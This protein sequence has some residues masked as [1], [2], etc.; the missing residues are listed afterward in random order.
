MAMLNGC[1]IICEGPMAEEKS[2]LQQMLDRRGAIYDEYLK[3]QKGLEQSIL[4]CVLRSADIAPKVVLGVSDRMFT[5]NEGKE[6]F[7]AIAALVHEGQPVDPVTVG[8]KLNKRGK[9]LDVG[10]APTLVKLFHNTVTAANIDRYIRDMRRNYQLRRIEQI[11]TDMAYDALENRS[12][13]DILASAGSKL[14]SLVNLSQ[15]TEGKEM[16]DVISATLDTIGK[17]EQKKSSL[18]VPTGLTAFD[19]EHGGL[20]PENLITIAARPGMGKTATA[21]AITA[22]AA[23]T[24]RPVFASIEM[25]VQQ[26]GE[27]LLSAESGVEAKSIRRGNIAKDDVLRLIEAGDKLA[28]LPI[29]MLDLPGATLDQLVLAVRA[30]SMKRRIDLLVIDYLQKIKKPSFRVQA[31]EHIAECSGMMATLARDLQC[32]VIQLAQI[33]R[34]AEKRR[35][36]RPTLADIKGSGSVEEDSDVVILLHWPHSQSAKEHPNLLQVIVAKNRHG[37]TGMLEVGFNRSNMQFF[38]WNKEASDLFD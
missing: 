23:R 18:A 12:P 7:R 16:A 28:M 25:S 6:I 33:N 29:E 15:R 1:L 30:S 11:G 10:G 13:D 38:D 34:E 3:Q 19:R 8:E 20:F 26:L 32:P 36:P 27:R 24:H 2:R 17:R 31:N 37:S 9:L 35:D 5:T 4:G 21:L 22:F 14:T